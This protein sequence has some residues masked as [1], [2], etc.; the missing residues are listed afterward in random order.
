MKRIG[1][2]YAGR[3]FS[4]GQED[5]EQMKADIEEAHRN[6]RAVW[7]RVN[8]GEGRPATGRPARR[9]RASRSR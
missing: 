5:F 3:E 1:I 2:I 9:T 4:I 8:H 7:I 6:G